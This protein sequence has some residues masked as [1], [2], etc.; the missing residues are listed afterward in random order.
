MRS[1]CDLI[2]FI[3]ALNNGTISIDE[4]GLTGSIQSIFFVP[5]SIGRSR[6][7]L[8]IISGWPL[9][10]ALVVKGLNELPLIFVLSIQR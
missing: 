2:G 5:F 4:E 7:K 3:P 6:N 10:A 1:W 9:L 8:A